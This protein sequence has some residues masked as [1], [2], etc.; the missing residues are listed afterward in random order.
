M[1]GYFDMNNNG[2]VDYTE[3]LAASLKSKIY[4]EEVTLR[5]AFSFFDQD[6][7]GKITVEEMANVLRSDDKL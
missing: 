3:F 4:L 1:I 6:K 2:M 5:R 7:N